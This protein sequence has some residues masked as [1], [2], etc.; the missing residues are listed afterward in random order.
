MNFEMKLV[1]DNSRDLERTVLQLFVGRKVGDEIKNRRLV[2]HAYLPV[3]SNVYEMKLMMLPRHTYFMRQNRDCNHRYTIFAKRYLEGE[4]T[5][6]L[7]PIGMGRLSSDKTLVEIY[8]PLLGWIIV[9]DLIP[10]N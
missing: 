1:Q 2:G 5:K 4:E 8:F 10:K 6:F 7:N 9:L 3:G